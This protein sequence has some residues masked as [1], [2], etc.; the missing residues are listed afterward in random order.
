M[1]SDV[2]GRF[3]QIS[4]LTVLILVLM[5]YGLW[6]EIIDHLNQ[7]CGLNPCSNGI[8]SLTTVVEDELKDATSRLNPCS[9][10]IWSLTL[11]QLTLMK[12]VRSLNPCSNGIWSLTSK[13][14]LCTTITLSLNPCSNGIWSLTVLLSFKRYCP[15]VLILVLME[16]GL[17]Q[18]LWLIQLIGELS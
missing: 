3:W 10:G 2:T 8:W 4:P 17:W 6:L 9:N 14:G 12:N 16:Y 18:K 5:E 11:M 13:E 7:E 1:V 15:H